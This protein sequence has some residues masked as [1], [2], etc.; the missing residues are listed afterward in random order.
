MNG[1]IACLKPPG[2]T[3]HDIVAAVR[4]RAGA[5]V[6]HLGTLDPAAAGVLV[7]ALGSATRLVAFAQ[8]WEKTYVADVW[9][10]L[11][12]HTD[13]DSGRP[14]GGSSAERVTR[15]EVEEALA[16]FVGHIRQRPPAVS[17]IKVGGERLYRMNR[18]DTV[19]Q[20]PEREVWVKSLELLGFD[21][22]RRAR[23]R[24]RMVCSKGVYVRSLAR[25][26]GQALGVGGTMG[27]LLRTR[28]GSL[29][30][31]ESVTVEEWVRE[32]RV[33]PAATLLAGLVRHRLEPGSPAFAAAA[34]LALVDGRGRIWGV[35]DPAPSGP[36][37][38]RRL[39][40]EDRP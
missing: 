5:K 25:D 9:L 21:P 8:G 22:G 23:V 31:R 6:G 20:A 4:R 3:S 14:V 27:F 24:L 7:L 19:V 11:V 17:A 1:V 16:G 13:D 33:L 38:I 18:T 2:P 34:P 29:H 39:G 28:V 37:R 26:L 30:V 10:G 15:T 35:L 40:E 12:T 32:P 36:G